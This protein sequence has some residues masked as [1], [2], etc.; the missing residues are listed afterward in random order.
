MKEINM[1]EAV[2]DAVVINDGFVVIDHTDAKEDNKGLT[3]IVNVYSVDEK[4]RKEEI[5]L[6]VRAFCSG[7][8]GHVSAGETSFS[9]S[10]IFRSNPGNDHML[11]KHRDPTK[12]VIIKNRATKEFFLIMDENVTLPEAENFV[13]RVSGEN[14]SAL[15]RKGN[16]NT[17]LR[18][19]CET[20]VGPMNVDGDTRFEVTLWHRIVIIKLQEY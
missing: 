9:F 2:G 19:P 12:M 14:H 15:K 10:G 18:F 5:D 20:M 8:G 16:F 13:R 17:R 7:S 4:I 6:M 3:T 1:K 11:K